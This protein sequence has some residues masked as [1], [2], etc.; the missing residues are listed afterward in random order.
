MFNFVLFMLFFDSHR[1]CLNANVTLS[2][3]QRLTQK[4]ISTFCACLFAFIGVTLFESESFSCCFSDLS[5][6][7]LP[8]DIIIL[9]FGEDFRKI[10]NKFSYLFEAIL[11]RN[12]H[13]ETNERIVDCCMVLKWMFCFCFRIFSIFESVTTFALL[14]VWYTG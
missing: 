14:Y 10:L 1:T 5:P 11:L 9:S 8:V 3:R 4:Q 12:I 7:P 6:S 2:L 13:T